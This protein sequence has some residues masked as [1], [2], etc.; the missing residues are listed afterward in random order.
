MY[1]CLCNGVSDRQLVE[2]AA[3]FA[4]VS[5]DEDLSSFA[6]RV[7]DRLGAGLGCGTCRTFAVELVERAAAQHAAVLLAAPAS[8]RAGCDVS[9]LPPRAG[10]FRIIPARDCDAS[11][12]RRA[13]TR[14]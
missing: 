5:A 9:P 3:E 13:K 14:V 6:Q 2:A 11:R 8:G 12:D 10:A 4:Q 7:T 1:V